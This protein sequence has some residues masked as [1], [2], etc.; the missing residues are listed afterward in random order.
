MI[1]L[2]LLKYLK[3]WNCPSWNLALWESFDDD[4][5]DE[6][7]AL[8]VVELDLRTTLAGNCYL[9]LRMVLDLDWVEYLS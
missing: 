7:V 1:L 3:I 6:R 9:R 5:D 4:G 8:E 2:I